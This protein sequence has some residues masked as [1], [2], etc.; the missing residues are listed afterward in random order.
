MPDCKHDQR[1]KLLKIRKGYEWS[2][3]ECGAFMAHWPDR[4]WNTLMEDMPALE[5]GEGFTFNIVE[6]ELDYIETGKPPC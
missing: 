2:C 1:I 6:K 5:K 3:A 4:V